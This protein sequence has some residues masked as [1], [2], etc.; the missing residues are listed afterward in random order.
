MGTGHGWGQGWEGCDWTGTRD[1]DVKKG[2]GQGMSECDAEMGTDR[3]QDKGGMEEEKWEVMQI[4][5]GMGTRWGWGRGRDKDEGEAGMGTREKGEMRKGWREAG[6]GMRESRRQG[7]NSGQSKGQAGTHRP[8]GCLTAAPWGGAV[9]LCRVGAPHQPQLVVQSGP[10]CSTKNNP[11]QLL[12]HSYCTCACTHRELAV[13]DTHLTELCM[14]NVHPKAPLCPQ[15]KATPRQ[16]HPK[17]EPGWGTVQWPLSVCPPLSHSSNCR[18]I[19]PNEEGGGRE[20]LL[21]VIFRE[22]SSV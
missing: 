13:I 4:Q 12:A 21:R 19:Y 22:F 8:Q 3:E 5:P 2:W 6:L 10:W 15:H 11:K 7:R 14:G 16:W 20:R 17:S 18:C 1:G 9:G